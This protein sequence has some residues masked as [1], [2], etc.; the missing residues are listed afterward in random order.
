MQC[1]SGTEQLLPRTRSL[2]QVGHLAKQVLLV[3][4]QP[5]HELRIL[6]GL[7][8]LLRGHAA[9]DAKPAVQK[10]SALLRQV[11]PA[12]QQVS[13]DFLLLFRR[14]SFQD[15]FP[16][17]HG[18][19]LLRGHLIP[20]LQGAP[21]LLLALRRQALKARVIAH[22]ALLFFRGHVPQLIDPFRREAHHRANGRL[23]LELLRLFLLALRLAGLRAR[24][25]LLL[26]RK[27]PLHRRSMGCGERRHECG[28]G[29]CGLEKLLHVSRLALGL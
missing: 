3:V 5:A 28:Y 13:H 15:L 2:A 17:A 22:K 25:L 29:A 1:A 16:V 11:L 7:L 19:A 4:V 6:Q 10:L 14:H 21:D 8:A 9:Q 20:A 24:T 26:G 12:W 18:I 27:V 23:V